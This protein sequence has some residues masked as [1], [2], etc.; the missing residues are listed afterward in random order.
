[1]SIFRPKRLYPPKKKSKKWK[2]SIFLQN[3][4]VFP[5]GYVENLFWP[6]IFIARN[7]CRSTS[8][9]YYFKRHSTKVFWIFSILFFLA[10]NS[11]DMTMLWVLNLFFRSSPRKLW[12]RIFGKMSQ[13]KF[14]DT[15]SWHAVNFSHI[16]SV[17]NP[18]F[19]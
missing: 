4:Q 8:E 6:T 7:F 13:K 2:K 10:F 18:K 9:A 14:F 12:K 3:F 15:Q 1:M 11:R 5:T 17:G 16:G 19:G